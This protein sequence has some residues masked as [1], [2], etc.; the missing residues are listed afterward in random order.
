MA[1]RCGHVCYNCELYKERVCVGCEAQ[2]I[3]VWGDSCPIKNCLISENCL[4]CPQY[5]CDLHRKNAVRVVSEV[6]TSRQLMT[7][8][9]QFVERVNELGFMTL[10]EN[11][12]GLPALDSETSGD[13]W[14]TGDAATDPWLWRT[15]AVEQKDLAY[16]CIIGGIRGFVAPRLYPL[17]WSHFHPVESLKALWEQGALAQHDWE[18]WQLF[19]KEHTLV[20][21][22]I[23]KALRSKLGVSKMD[24]ALRNLEKHYYITVSGSQY[25]L[26]KQG[27]PYGWPAAIYSTTESWLD[28]KFGISN[29]L[30][31]EVAYKELRQIFIDLGI[32]DQNILKKFDL[33]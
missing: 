3:P 23:R 25:K 14:H 15:Q 1:A 33:N 28:E 17:F 22:D 32:K 29:R 24:Q 27:Q 9:P 20:S 5:R 13:R 7:S 21:T 16:G 19:E 6:A 11:K 26:N 12:W 8:Y 4:E 18:M 2:A 30:S 10:C 31:P